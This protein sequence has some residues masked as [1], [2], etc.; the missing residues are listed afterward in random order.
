M[1]A[2]H[3]PVDAGHA[4]GGNKTGLCFGSFP[5]QSGRRVRCWRKVLGEHTDA[6]SVRKARV[7]LEKASWRRENVI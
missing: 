2:L 5:L 7:N 3:S 1:P 6:A 4:L